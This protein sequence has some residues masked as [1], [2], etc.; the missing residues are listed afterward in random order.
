MGCASI[1]LR[2][3]WSSEYMSIPLSK[4]NKEWQKLWFYLRNNDDTPLPIFIG[5]LIEE[6]SD[7]WRYRPIAKEQKW[8]GDLLKANVALK[9]HNLRGISI[10]GAYHVRRLA[11]LMVC[12]LLMYKMTPDSTP[13][14]TVMVA[15]EA[16][17]VGEMAQRI[18][19]V[20]EC[21]TDLS[22]DLSLVYPVPG[23]PTMHRTWVS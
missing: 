23:H 21:P 11:P 9:G 8:L 5:R 15:S 6:A 10:I 3:K 7:A 18:M 17:S 22:V 1:R 2:G 20:M 4:S 19:E 12:T 13:D 14:G 16:L